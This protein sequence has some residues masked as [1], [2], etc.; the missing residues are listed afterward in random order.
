V[1]P[2]NSAAE[3]F[4]IDFNP[5]NLED[6]RYRLSVQGADASGNRSAA[7]AYQVDFQVISKPSITYFFPYPNPFSTATRFTFT[8]TGTEFPD[9]FAIQIFSPTGRLVK[10][11]SKAEFGPLRIGSNLS[12][13]R[14]EGTDEKGNRLPNGLYMY[15]VVL[16]DDLGKFTHRQTAADHTISNG[17]GKLSIQR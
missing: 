16:K 7:T 17:F 11:I 4:R 3:L 14:W 8:L 13:Y 10:Q 6:G 2:A 1:I 15:K 12:E 5:K 9:D